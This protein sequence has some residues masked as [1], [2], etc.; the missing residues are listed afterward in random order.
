MLVNNG[1]ASASEIV[2]GALQ[3]LKR[4]IVVGE[5][6]F[7]KGSV[8]MILAVDDTEAIRLTVAR[9]YLPSGRTIQ[10]VGVSPDVLVYPGKV[11]NDDNGFNIK[12]S[13]LKQ[14]LKSELE[15]I[16]NKK[17]KIKDDKNIITQSAIYDDIQLKTAIDTIKIMQKLQKT[18][19]NPQ[20]EK[21]AKR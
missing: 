15:K 5:K 10:A 9:Y 14:H 19:E 2:S 18:D 12:E 1:S 21:N 20:G 13:D 7:G 11:P 6:T 8:Q 16:S 4:A 3:D 17:E